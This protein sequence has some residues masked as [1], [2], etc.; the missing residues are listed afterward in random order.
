MNQAITAPQ[1]RLFDSNGEDLGI[2]TNQE[3]QQKAI[4]AEL[5]LVEVDPRKNP[6]VCRIDD[7]GKQAFEEKKKKSNSKKKQKQ[8]QTKSIRIKPRIGE[9][10][11]QVK[12][13]SMIR[14]LQT[15]DKARVNL[16][17]KGREMAHPEMGRELL[18]RIEADLATYGAVDQPP[19]TEGRQLTMVFAPLKS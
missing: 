9:A 4:A 12:L 14:F 6:P 17:F 7:Y 11:Y 19:K 8:A 18:R 5:D 16:S 3:A 15:G 10:D 13:K 1:V 2:V